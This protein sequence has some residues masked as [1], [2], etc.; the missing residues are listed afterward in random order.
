MSLTVSEGNSDYTPLAEGSY[1]AVCYGVIDL[2]LQ[3]NEKY[4]TTAN[5]VLVM[6]ELPDEVEQGGEYPRVFSQRYTA[7]LNNKSLLRK[8][9][10]AWRGRDFTPEELKRFDLANLLGVPCLIQIVHREGEGKV[11]ANLASIMALPKGMPRPKAKRKL[12]SFNLD[13]D[14]L[15]MLADM[16]E[17]VRDTV[18]KSESYKKRMNAEADKAAQPGKEGEAAEDPAA[19]FREL[20]SCDDEELPF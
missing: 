2:G 8:H 11:F 20:N 16:P 12:I 15:A 5:K 1:T 19:R 3:V 13:E 10:V 14:D 18:M 17:W 4:G 7:S 6:W 9:L